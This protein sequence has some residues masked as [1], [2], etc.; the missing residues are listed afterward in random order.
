MKHTI[1]FNYKSSE[2][3]YTIEYELD[4]VMFLLED[5]DLIRWNWDGDEEAYEIWL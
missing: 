4:R 5:L 1:K 2:Q 3:R